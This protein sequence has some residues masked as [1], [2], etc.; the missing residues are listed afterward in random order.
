MCS[1]IR[2]VLSTL[3]DLQYMISMFSYTNLSNNNLGKE[4][5][6][7]IIRNKIGQAVS[8]KNMLDAVEKLGFIMSQSS[9]SFFV[10]NK[11]V[12]LLIKKFFKNFVRTRNFEIFLD[13]E[14]S[15]K[16]FE[17]E[18]SKNFEFFRFFEIC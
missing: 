17:L 5:S 16:N 7:R 12:F 1:K 18:K 15:E 11:M 13:L 6:K 2:A 3:S 4:D 10:E 8:L 9:L 14:I